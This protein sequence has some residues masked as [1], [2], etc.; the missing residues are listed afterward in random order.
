MGEENEQNAPPIQ[1]P[2]LRV[3][4]DLGGG[5]EVTTT[6]IVIIVLFMFVAVF[7]GMEEQK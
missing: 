6:I 5:T 7:D 4:G 2:A 3:V 1:V